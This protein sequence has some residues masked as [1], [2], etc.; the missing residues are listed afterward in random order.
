[1]YRRRGSCGRRQY[2]AAVRELKEET[3]LCVNRENGKLIFEIIK[4]NFFSDIW[5][6]RQD[7][8][9]NDVILQENE[10]TAAKYAAK[11]EILDMISGNK[12][13]AYDYIPELFKKI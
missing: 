13:I 5:L 1:M 8:D 9:I 12:F 6:F 2:Y 4:N 7:F 11:E 10:T 3:G